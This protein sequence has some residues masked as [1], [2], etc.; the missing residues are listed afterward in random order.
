ML[1]KALTLLPTDERALILLYYMEEKTI[2]EVS[3]ISGLT[4][5]NVKTKLF[6]IRKK[7]FVLL[8]GMEE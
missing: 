3:T 6:R 8:K 2:E 1:D 7:L 5:S 4:E